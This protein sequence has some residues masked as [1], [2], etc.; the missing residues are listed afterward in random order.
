MLVTERAVCVAR[1]SN[2]EIF[3]DA[4]Y[5]FVLVFGDKLRCRRA[6]RLDIMKFIDVELT[7]DEVVVEIGLEYTT[8]R[9]CKIFRK[10][11]LRRDDEK[12][13]LAGFPSTLRD[14]RD[15][16]TSSGA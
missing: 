9:I 13:F 3:T 5:Q 11:L 2:L 16:L 10:S 6:I 1:A 14:S 7:D 12:P 4:A 8:Q 15:N